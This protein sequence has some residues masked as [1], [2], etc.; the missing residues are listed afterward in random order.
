MLGSTALNAHFCSLNMSNLINNNYGSN[1]VLYTTKT[2]H[3]DYNFSKFSQHWGE[4]LLPKPN[5]PSHP[6][7]YLNAQLFA[8]SLIENCV[9]AFASTQKLLMSKGK[10][11]I[12][13]C[14]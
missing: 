1:T 7:S 4:C 6:L 14:N 2:H 3:F 13:Y 5:P 8:P 11:V 10:K 12:I 9:P